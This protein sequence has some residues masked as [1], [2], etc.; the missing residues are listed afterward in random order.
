MVHSGPGLLNNFNL[1]LC[2]DFPQQRSYRSEPTTSFLSGLRNKLCHLQ[3]VAGNV[4]CAGVSEAAGDG[5]S[6]E[7]KPISS[8]YLAVA[9]AIQCAIS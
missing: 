3:A 4:L 2:Q 1:H 7:N 8:S 6:F 5:V 9:T